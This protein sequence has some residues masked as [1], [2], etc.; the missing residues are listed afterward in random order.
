MSESSYT[1]VEDPELIVQSTQLS[2]SSF[3]L[4]SDDHEIIHHEKK[5]F[6]DVLIYNILDISKVVCEYIGDIILKIKK[7]VFFQKLMLMK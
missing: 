4:T 7:S 1:V 3:L 2:E 5:S 6:S